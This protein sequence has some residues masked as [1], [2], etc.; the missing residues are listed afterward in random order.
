MNASGYSAARTRVFLGSEATIGERVELPAEESQHIFK[1]LRAR[2]G[3]TVELVTPARRLMLARVYGEARSAEAEV[4]EEAPV[5]QSWRAPVT[6]YQAI[7]KGKH[8][9]LVVEK[10]TELGV[11]RIVPLLSEQGEVSPAPDKVE[12]WRRIAGAAARQ[13]LQ[14]RVPEISEPT[15]FADALGRVSD[16]SDGVS[17]IVLH[18]E[19]GIPT[20]EDA[21]SA[22]GAIALFVGPEGGWSQDEM[23]L[24]RERGLVL[25][26]MGPYR[27][28]A[29]TA[30][31]V[32][33]AR[34]EARLR[35]LGSDGDGEVRDDTA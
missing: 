21:V 4:V 31:M 20:L 17:G 14:L 23:P 13:S 8:M 6:L 15:K 19:P 11:E 29:E 16:E 22:P 35:A 33:V 9:D 18:N 24:A 12:R 25:A 26:Q 10:A 28:R 27:L 2:A 1:V 32:A 5:A 3:E 34:A 30:G 7:P